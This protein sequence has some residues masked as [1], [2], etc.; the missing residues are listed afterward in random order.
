MIVAAVVHVVPM[1]D[2]STG[3]WCT[4]CA[5]PSVVTET[6]EVWVGDG[7]GPGRL[8]TIRHCTDCGRTEEV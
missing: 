5:L 4:P 8:W 1:G 7:P 6:Y 2:L 3:G